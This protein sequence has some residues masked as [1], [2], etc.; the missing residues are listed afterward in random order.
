[1]EIALNYLPINNVPNHVYFGDRPCI[2]ALA[3][4]LRGHGKIPPEIIRV[5]L[6]MCLM[7]VHFRDLHLDHPGGGYS[8]YGKIVISATRQ[9]LIGT[10]LPI[11]T[12]IYVWS[13][14]LTYYI[15]GVINVKIRGRIISGDYSG[16][17]IQRHIRITIAPSAIYLKVKP[18]ADEPDGI[19]H[20]FT[21]TLAN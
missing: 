8:I 16:E 2:N 5:I 9:N 13:V 4:V 7:R 1:M 21:V 15:H 10:R 3:D 6:D 14:S 11:L 19:T 18:A 17:Y 12:T 20:S